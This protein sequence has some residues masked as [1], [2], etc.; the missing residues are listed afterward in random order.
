M[1]TVAVIGTGIAGMGAAYFLRERYD[2]TLYEK[3]N[4][5]GGHTHT[6]TIDEDGAPVFIDTAFMVYNEITYPNLIRLFKELGVKTKNTD[7]SFS[8]QHIPSGLEFC[9][10]G[11]SGLFAQRRNLFNIKHWQMLLEMDRFNKEAVQILDDDTYTNCSLQEYVKEKG[12]SD[13]FFYKFLIPI[14]SAVWST[15]PDLMLRFPAVT[16]VRFFKNHGF[17]GLRGHYQWK[18]VVEGSQ[19][20]REKILAPFKEK[21]LLKT[22]VKQVRRIGDRVEVVD[23]SGGRK[24]FDKVILAGHADETLA[25]LAE[26]TRQERELLGRFSYQSNSATLHTDKSVMPKIRRAWSSWNYRVDRNHPSTVY[27]MNNLQHVSKKRDYFISI[28]GGDE[29][30][31]SKVIWKTEY[32][33]PVFNVEAIKAQKDL[34]SL[35]RN[36]NIYF[37][38]GY[39][40]YGFHEDALTSGLEAARALTGEMLWG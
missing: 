30:D 9:G 39:F 23:G 37:C 17:L 6:L 29:I 7:M 18:T 1:K 26:P 8:V 10:T 15:P 33:H 25:M 31:A 28:N 13:D 24:T 32:A 4:Y 3:N 27:W 20:Y 38:G 36:G 12:Y 19:R 34:P 14:S 5:P 11:L 22:P 40:K 35:N 2:I 21:I 16:L